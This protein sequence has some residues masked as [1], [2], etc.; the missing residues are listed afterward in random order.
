M[1]ELAAAVLLATGLA[2]RYNPGIMDPV[3]ANRVEW[4]QIDTRQYHVGYVAMLDRDDIGR[5]V[6]LEHPDGRVVGPVIVADCAG[7]A[8]RE[9]LQQLGWAVDLSYEL[10]VQLDVV[11]DIV[12][13]FKVWDAAP[14]GRDRWL[15]GKE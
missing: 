9:R 15:V 2:T 8:D 6:W 11:H 3:V 5:L 10:A 12:R 13:D 7:E 14:V 4:G 1:S